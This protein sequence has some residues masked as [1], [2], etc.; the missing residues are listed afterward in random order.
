MN[1]FDCFDR[2]YC[3]HIPNEKRRSLI[4][5]EFTRIGIN[6]RVQYVHA[7][8][9][10]KGF[11]MSN[12][13][14]APRGEFGVNLSQIKAIVH[15][16]SDGAKHPLFLEDDVIFHKNAHELLETSLKDL[17]SDWDIL[18]LGGH[19]TGP[20]FDPQATK[21]SDT[22]AK[23]GK[24]SFADSYTFNDGRLIQFFDGWCNE[25]TRQNA[26]YDFIL[27]Q[28]AKRSNAYCTYPLLCNQRPDKSQISGKYDDKS[29][30]VAR[31]WTHHIG[32]KDATPEHKSIAL[33]W[34]KENPDKWSVLKKRRK[35]GHM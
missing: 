10:P 18:Y 32:D 7:T 29:S 16:I 25:I 28:Y 4:E 30:I 3:I 34:R 22:L 13:R 15:A 20:I 11:T 17:P 21:F 23:V 35:Q 12:M 5:K 27:G 33:K 8:P 1:P 9:P 2:I 26:M 19:P 14:R 6:E 24:F 31:A